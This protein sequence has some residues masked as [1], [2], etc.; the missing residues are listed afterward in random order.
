[1]KLRRSLP[2]FILAIVLV[3]TLTACNRDVLQEAVDEINSDE[4][5]HAELE[6]L[7]NVRAE[8]RGDST[9]VVVFKAE[10]EELATAEISQVVAEGGASEFQK[11]VEEMRKARISNPKVILEFLDMSG[12]LIYTRE[13][14]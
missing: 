6:G 11:A 8:K 10:L 12:S 1:M 2:V 14:N 13:F 9:I 7:Y 3:F 4:S 5:L